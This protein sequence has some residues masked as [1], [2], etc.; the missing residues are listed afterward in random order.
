MWLWGKNLFQ[1]NT[2]TCEYIRDRINFEEIIQMCAVCQLS[3]LMR[4]DHIAKLKPH[5]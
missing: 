4:Y 3:F 1:P 2:L 5:R